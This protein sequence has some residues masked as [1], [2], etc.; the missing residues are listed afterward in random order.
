M[1]NLVWSIKS[2]HTFR[3]NMSPPSSYSSAAKMEATCS[4]G[5][6]IDFFF[7]FFYSCCSQLEHKASVKSFVSLQFLNLRQLVGLLGRGSARRKAT[8]YHKHRINTDIHALSGTRTHDH[9]VRPGEDISCLRPRG[10]CD[11]L[12]TDYKPLYPRR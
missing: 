8:T 11:R 9:N 4:C 7:F 3:R 2:L 12:S 5:T 1:D 10:H 6:S